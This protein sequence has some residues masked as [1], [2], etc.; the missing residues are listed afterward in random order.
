MSNAGVK[1]EKENTEIRGYK[2]MKP[3]GQGKFSIVYKAENTETGECVA[4]KCIK[5]FDMTDVKQREKC[6][7]EVK[8][9][10][11]LDHP[12]IIQYLDSFIENNDLYIAVEWA[13]KGDLKYIVKRAIQ[14][15]SHLDESKVWQYISQMAE[16]L[17][18]MHSKRIMHRDLKPAN[19]FID[20][21]GM[22]KLGDLGLGR[23]MS[24]QT[25]EAYSRVGTP[26]YMSPEVLEGSGYDTK[27]DVWSLG[28]IAY[29]L[30][31]LKSP[32]RKQNQSMSLYDLF[33]SIKAG[34]FDPIPD[35][36]SYKLKILIESI[37]KTNPVERLD[38]DQIV[39]ICDMHK[40]SEAK[41]PKID[42][43]LIMD[44][45]MDKLKLLDY[46]RKFALKPISRIFFSHYEEEKGF[47]KCEYLYE[48]C[49]WLM[50]LSQNKNSR[51][52]GVYLP[53]KTN[54][55]SEEAV[56]R[57]L[58][59]CKKFGVKFSSY[60]EEHQLLQGFGDSVCFLVDELLNR[61]LI[62]RDY[63]FEAPIMQEDSDEE[64]EI[65]EE[66]FD[67]ANIINIDKHQEKSKL[68]KAFNSSMRIDNGRITQTTFGFK[69][70]NRIMNNNTEQ[71]P[72]DLMDLDE[73]MITCSI[74]P[75]EWKKEVLHVEKD[76]M[77]FYAT[78][79]QEQN[80]PVN[81]CLIQ[82]KLVKSLMPEKLNKTIQKS[83][84]SLYSDLYC[85]SQQENKINTKNCDDV[86][87]L[88]KINANKSKNLKELTTLRDSM[89]S[90]IV[91]F[92][93][94]TQKLEIAHAKYEKK[95]KEIGSTA[96]IDKIKK[97]TNRIKVEVFKVDQRIGI[98]QACLAN[99]KEDNSKAKELYDELF[100]L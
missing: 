88:R 81:D 90:K 89:K 99:K 84:D 75:E 54:K 42:S 9:L 73:S 62:R 47:N 22:L 63:K 24:S 46:E 48:L 30:C 31:A 80:Y 85:I 70:D 28:C 71:E 64:S 68:S 34:V 69:T 93:D 39:S 96:K 26:L 3:I 33:Q 86:T 15:D 51:R 49:Y 43:Y 83:V 98:I 35:R 53:F 77:K 11:S 5:I 50:S 97:A 21:E 18:H 57:L 72:E 1:P 16:A 25:L 32:F 100:E 95:N 13:E 8:L 65:E 36:Y 56:K 40:A 94:L 27:S 12:N 14:E 17:A 61:E 19:I 7:K 4:L 92:D 91:K 76:L 6:L 45:I 59:D 37:I 78:L 66:K 20:S 29:E 79:N 52:I 58:A 55:S 23:A 10:Q 41:K 82:C 74:K 44:D 60:F 87:K 67:E 2:I 38:I